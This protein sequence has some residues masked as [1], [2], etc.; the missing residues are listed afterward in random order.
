MLLFWGGVEDCS[1]PLIPYSSQ[2][3]AIVG[4]VRQLRGRAPPVA[5][6]AWKPCRFLS[7]REGSEPDSLSL[8]R[9]VSVRP[10]CSHHYHY[11][12]YPQFC[13]V[14]PM[15]ALLPIDS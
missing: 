13:T 14:P 7:L 6:V 12:T 5:T 3:H 1:C 15:H 8:C 10:Y 11:S 4:L 9:L 2:P